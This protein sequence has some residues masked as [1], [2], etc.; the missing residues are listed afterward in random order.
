MIV[1]HAAG[2]EI[3]G[4]ERSLLDLLAAIDHRKYEMSCI[5]PQKNDRYLRAV[6][7]HTRSIEV[8][9]FHWWNRERPFDYEAVSRFEA[10]FRRERAALVHVNTITLMDPLLAAGRLGIPSI[11]HVREL[12]S[13]DDHLSAGFGYKPQEIVRKVRTASDFIIANSHATYR[14][15]QR[16][17]RSFQLYNSVDLDR[18]D[19]TN[20]LQPGRLKIGIISSNLPIKG[21][22]DFVRLA[23]QARRARPELEFYVIGPRNEHVESLKRLV[24]REGFPPNL[25]FLGYFNDSVEAMEQVNVV[26]CLSLVAESFG[27]TVAE[28]MAARRPI[29]AYERGAVPELI[30]H[31]KDGFFIPYPDF[32]KALDYLGLLADQPAKVL[33]MGANGRERAEKLFSP[34]LFKQ[35]LNGIYQQ[36]FDAW[37]ARDSI[38]ARPAAQKFSAIENTNPA[39]K[40]PNVD[41]SSREGSYA[42]AGGPRLHEYRQS[43]RP[44]DRISLET[45]NRILRRRLAIVSGSWGW[46]LLSMYRRWLRRRVWHSPVGRRYYEPLAQWLLCR[47][48]GTSKPLDVF[49]AEDTDIHWQTINH[50]I[51]EKALAGE[52]IIVECDLPLAKSGRKARG[53]TKVSGWVAAKSGVAEVLASID[54][55]SVP[56]NCGRHTPDIGMHLPD[57]LG[58]SDAGFRIRFDCSEYSPG[59]HILKIEVRSDNGSTTSLIRPFEVDRRSPYSAWIEQNEPVKEGIWT[60]TRALEKLAYRPKISIVMAVGKVQS[61]FLQTCIESVLRQIYPHWELCVAARHSR[62][63][64]VDEF[65]QQF[66]RQDKRI[67]IVAA[68]SNSGES[69]ATNA[70]L[71][72]CSG[73]FVAFLE[74]HDEIA[75]FALFE[76]SAVLNNDKAIDVVY[77]DEDR[78]SSD[79]ERHEPFFKPEYS[80]DLLR[81]CN[82]IG[83]LLVARRALLETLGGPR[84]AFESA[85]NYDLILRLTEKTS[86]IARVS[87]IL[88]HRRNV[89]EAVLGKT[90]VSEAS[91][92]GKRALEEHLKRTGISGSVD[93]MKPGTYRVRYRIDNEPEVAIVIPTGGQVARLRAVVDSVLNS[94]DYGRFRIVVADNSTDSSVESYVSSLESNGRVSRTDFRGLPFNFSAMCNSAARALD[95]PLYLFLNDD[96]EVITSNWLESLVE[97]GVRPGV[98]AVGARLRFPDNTLQHAGVVMGVQGVAGHA[99]RGLTAGGNSHFDFSA[100]TRNYSAVT[101]ACLLTRADVFWKLEGFDEVHLQISFQ[102]IDFCLRAREK[103]YRI[104]YTPYAELRHYES[105]SRQAAGLLDHPLEANYMRQRWSSWIE[106]DPYYNPNL[107]R[108]HENFEIRLDEL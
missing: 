65:L 56:V 47:L 66:A 53:I 4:A 27:R 11:I 6:A 79:G 25:H 49:H 9:P 62:N 38:L 107:T 82:Y 35:N 55:G 78:I 60:G 68:T 92:V 72:K 2:D 19:L 103:G 15:F 88:Y 32:A 89:P 10:I 71:S 23:V 41:Y 95:A 84:K 42:V 44:I 76:I 102:D 18:F 91:Q 90:A 13:D 34:E 16:D 106:N 40:A 22:H 108:E 101:G 96:V 5:L 37:E 33:E 67:R 85:Q 17:G 3:F 20:E 12:I 58:S 29:I 21:I 14:L 74:P 87:K 73:E 39:I 105:V 83:G 36:I 99:F 77:S 31:A 46:Q 70:A 98:G 43:K 7:K 61:Q 48:V 26:L 63:G 45:E 1:G 93:E 57:Y 75:P 50:S 59:T 81:S 51:L 69:V 104:V 97:H 64:Q 54:G 28:A 100:L 86:N 80:P 24:R 52:E 8:F 30:R 94:T